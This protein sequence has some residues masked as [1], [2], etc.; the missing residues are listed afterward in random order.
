MRGCPTSAPCVA[1]LRCV[2]LSG[3]DCCFRTTPLLAC[4]LRLPGL[5]VVAGAAEEGRVDGASLLVDDN[6]T[7]TLGGISVR[8][9]HTPCHTRGHISY[10]IDGEQPLVFTGDTLFG[11]GCGKFFEGSA[12]QMLA[13]LTKLAALPRHT[14]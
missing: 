9:L 12:P 7:L 6:A 3:F 8:A 11:G 2:A 14:L 10:F 13:S 1:A 5:Q 4:C